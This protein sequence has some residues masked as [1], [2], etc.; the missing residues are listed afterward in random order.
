MN[1]FACIAHTAGRRPRK[2]G[3][4]DLDAPTS[5]AEAVPFATLVAPKRRARGKRGV[6]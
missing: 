4:V 5:D 1:R 6:V 2:A 3:P